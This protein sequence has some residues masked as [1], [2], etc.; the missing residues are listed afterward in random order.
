MSFPYTSKTLKNGNTYDLNARLEMSAHEE[1]ATDMNEQ[2]DENS[3]RFSPDIIEEKIE[4]NLEPLHAQISAVAG[5]M[6]R[7]IQGKSARK[8]TTLKTREP[9]PRSKS[10]FAK[11]SGTSRFH[12]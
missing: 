11:A 1:A 6:D 7:L 8:F 2:N 12:L 4:A 9:Q 3:A 10:L 5:M